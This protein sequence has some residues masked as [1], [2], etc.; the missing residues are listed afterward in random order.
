MIGVRTFRWFAWANLVLGGLFA[1]ITL[2]FVPGWFNRSAWADVGRSAVNIMMPLFFGAV[3]F[4]LIRAGR[5]HLRS[6]RRESALALAANT[7]VVIFGLSLGILRRPTFRDPYESFVGVAAL[8]V[9]YSIHRWL[10]RPAAIRCFH[11]ENPDPQPPRSVTPAP[12]PRQ[13]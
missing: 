7:A 13:S 11:A 5:D 4:A 12:E 2:L 3:T 10:L 8:A 6:P 1:L 9:A